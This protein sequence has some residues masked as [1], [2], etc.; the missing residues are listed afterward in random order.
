[1][2]SI[3]LDAVSPLGRVVAGFRRPRN[4]GRPSWLFVP[5]SRVIADL[6][7]GQAKARPGAQAR[8][9]HVAFLAALFGMLAAVLV[10][11][12]VMVRSDAL[13][14]RHSRVFWNPVECYKF[15]LHNNKAEVA[16][17]GDSSLVFGI[18]PRLVERQTHVSSINLGLSAGGLVPFPKLLLDH[19]LKRNQLP[20]MIVLYVSPWTMVRNNPDMPHLWNDGARVALR[21]GNLAEDASIFLS[22][23]RRLIQFPMIVL[24]QGLSQFSLSGAWWNVASSEMEQDEGWFA[25]H[26]PGRPRS[27][28]H[29][30]RRQMLTDSCH[31]RAKPLSQPDRVALERFRATY[32]HDGMRVLIYVAPVPACDPSY[33]GIVSA[34]RGIADNRPQ[35]LPGHYFVDDGWRVHLDTAGSVQASRQF[36]AF[37][38]SHIGP[39]RVGP[40]SALVRRVAYN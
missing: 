11:P 6:V 19:Y 17:V 39:R 7:F 31:L 33:P 8:S 15:G 22:D 3:K 37:L 30:G 18:Q 9:R 23:P 12:Y 40:P 26:R 27:V 1:V 25:L 21:D 36:A 28:Q 14:C 35:T 5:R 38:G 13:Y 16:L 29:P 20:R 4:P 34:Y 2:P 10:A 24:Q 32:Q